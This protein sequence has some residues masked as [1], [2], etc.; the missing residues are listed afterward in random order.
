MDISKGMHPLRFAKRTIQ[1]KPAYPNGCYTLK[2]DDLT[3]SS[4][5]VKMTSTNLQASL[6]AMIWVDR[7]S[8]AEASAIYT[9]KAYDSRVLRIKRVGHMILTA[10]GIEKDPI[11]Y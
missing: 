7:N 6:V 10:L 1:K 11:V 4:P 5:T 9:Q 8:G 3:A 2:F